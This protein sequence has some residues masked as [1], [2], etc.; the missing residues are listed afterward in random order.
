M[1]D[2]CYPFHS[3]QRGLGV[4]DAYHSH[5]ACQIAQS[6]EA[7]DRL[8][9]QGPGWPECR[10]CAMHQDTRPLTR[11]LALLSL[12]PRQSADPLFEQEY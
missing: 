3:H 4:V 11:S 2:N 7:R 10:Y 9:G 12:A 1:W 8:S 6:I 5:P